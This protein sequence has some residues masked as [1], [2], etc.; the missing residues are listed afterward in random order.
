MLEQV[1]QPGGDTQEATQPGTLQSQVE[2]SP[3]DVQQEAVTQTSTP[4]VTEKTYSEAQ[5]RERETARNREVADY[6]QALAQTVLQ[7]QI[8]SL[9]D[10]EAQSQ[11]QDARAVDTGEITQ[12]QAQQRQQ[13]RIAG[14]RQQMQFQQQREEMGGRLEV[15]QAVLGR[16]EAAGRI[17]A[18]QDLAK[19]YEVD[20]AE[21]LKDKA[22]VNYPQMEA[23]A[24][25]LALRKAKGAPET[26][27]S[28]HVGGTRRNVDQMSAEEK[29]AYGLRQRR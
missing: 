13:Q 22:I 21:L 19:T 7:A 20:S 11:A 14:Y 18:A 17:L 25:K 28:G 3:V 15:A 24:A 2:V 23:A 4:A 10:Q 9:Q 1:T 16:A 12:E 26:F 5:W 8:R 29:V 27:D 6:R